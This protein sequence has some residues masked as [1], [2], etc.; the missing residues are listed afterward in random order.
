[1]PAHTFGVLA[2]A[3]IA[4]VVFAIGFI[5]HVHGP[6]GLVHGVLDWSRLSDADTRAAGRFTALVIYAMGFVLLGRAALVYYLGS[7]VTDSREFQLVVPVMLVALT[8]SLVIGLLPYRKRYRG[9][10]GNLHER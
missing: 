10:S 9:R 6:E 4:A 8:I 2:F 3:A 7:M 5:I 1:M